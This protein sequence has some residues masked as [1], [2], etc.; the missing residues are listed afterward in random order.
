MA[1]KQQIESSD[2]KGTST[3][4]AVI[5]A[6]ERTGRAGRSANRMNG[7]GPHRPSHHSGDALPAWS[8][9]AW[10]FIVIPNFRHLAQA[11]GSS[12]ARG[13]SQEI[14]QRLRTC[15][16]TAHGADL[17]RVRDD[18]FLLRTNEAFAAGVSPASLQ[19]S[20]HI[21]T[22]LAT[23]SGEPV[24]VDGTV[25]LAHVHAGWMPL[26]G[27]Q[28]PTPSDMELI[29]WVWAAQP[30]PDERNAAS[31]E[32]WGEQYRADMRMA[33]RV[34]NAMAKGGSTLAWRPVIDAEAPAAAFYREAAV[35]I[36]HGASEAAP[37]AAAD[38]MPCLERLGLGRGF[39][40]MAVRDVANRLRD[41][42]EAS[43]ATKISAS[44]AR[45]DHWWASLLSFLKAHP[46]LAK[47]LVVEIGGSALARDPEAAREFCDALRQHGVRIAIGQLGS[48]AIGL[49]IA[50]CRP[51][52]IKLDAS[53]VREA[54]ES[55]LGQD[56]LRE[57]LWLCGS[58]APLV[59]VDGVDGEDE[60][61]IALRA[62]AR[63]LQGYYLGGPRTPAAAAARTPEGGHDLVRA[64]ADEDILFP[65]AV[66]LAG[67]FSIA[68]AALAV[69]LQGTLNLPTLAIASAGL[70][71][72][73]HWSFIS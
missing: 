23:L 26:S 65:A 38:F 67:V 19:A 60:L 53:F 58:L 70:G 27:A 6:K 34:Y 73:A 9:R 37:F 47:R 50:R 72:C 14:E 49:E 3:A 64:P 63:W 41:W 33:V 8:G 17:V 20:E 4:T 2:V 45:L 31:R 1:S 35:Q 40:R 71:A 48:D 12:F 29:S 32:T 52:I 24:H 69:T 57:R 68:A 54:R 36:P 61:G 66:V 13:V 7:A 16:A 25:A 22:L 46:A 39:D 18:G 21:E 55:D 44:S 5:A 59:V 28:A 11:Y 10:A 43:L 56:R 51:E 30:L 15:F 62:G 42:P